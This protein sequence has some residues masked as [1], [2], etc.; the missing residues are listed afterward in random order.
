MPVPAVRGGAVEYLIDLY[1]AYNEQHQL[2]DITIYSVADKATKHHP[3]LSSAVNHYRYIN[4]FT[5]WAKIRKKLQFKHNNYYNPSIE[6]FLHQ[7]LQDIRRQHYDLIIVE[8]RPGYILKLR[9]LTDARCVLHLHN[10]F[11]NAKSKEATAIVEGFDKIICVSEFVTQQIPDGGDKSETVYNAIDVQ[12]FLDAKPLEREAIGLSKEDF[13]IVYSGRL[14]KDKGIL[15]LVEAIC[16]LTD[17]PHLK[18]LVV[19]ASAYG[20]DTVPT[21][22]IQQLQAAAAPIRDKI[23]LT[24]FID[25]Q[26]MPAYLKMANIAVVPS[27]WEEP[28][29]LTVVEAMA[30]GLPLIATRSGGIPEICEGAALLIERDNCSDQLVTAIRNLYQHPEQCQQLSDAAQQRV[31]Q[32]DKES[33]SK[34]FFKALMTILFLLLP[35]MT[36]AQNDKLSMWLRESIKTEKQITDTKRAESDMLATVF[37]RTSETLTE[38]ML[39]EY[40][41]TI[42]AQLGDISIITIPLSQ[43]GKL[44][45]NPTVLR[46]EAN[47]RADITLDTVPLVSNILPVYQATPQ[48]QAFTGS[49]VVVGLMDI[50]FDLTHPTFYNNVSLSDYRIKAFWDQLAQH[51]QASTSKLPV[52]REFLTQ[53]DILAQGCAIDG[54]M[55]GHGTHTAGIAAGSGYDSPYRGVAYESELCLVA[56]A[57]TSDTVFINPQDY[58]L[59][60]SATDALG[61]KYIFDYAEQQKKPCVVS[62]S[63]GYT[64]YMDDD[65]LLFNDFLERLIGPGRILVSSAGNES[66]ELT[67]FDKPIGK[68]QA[69]AFLKSGRNAPLYRLKSDKPVALTFYAY[70]GSNTP[71]H[72][73]QISAD[74]ERWNSVLIDTLF[75]DNDT[76]SV[77][78]NSYPSAFDQQGMISMVQ[79]YSNVTINKLPPIALVIGGKEQHATVI[80]TY[81]NALA[82]LDTDSRW[83]DASLGYNVLSPGCLK[84]PI[85]VASTSHRIVFKNMEG[86]WVQYPF[87]GEEIGLWSPYS[88]V[89][90]TLD[91]RIKPDIAAPGRCIVSAYNSYYLEEHPTATSYDV[92]H[93][94]VNGRTYP[95]HVDSGT[96]M[97][98]PVVAGII[99]LWLQA[100]PDLTRDDIMGILQRTSHHPEKDLDYPNN[101]YGYGEI[102]AYRGL[103]DILG[104]TAIKEVSQH[105]PHDAT[106]WAQDGLL[107]IAFGKIP[108]KPI[109]LTIYSTA[110]TRVFQTSVTTNQSDVTLP[111]PTFSKGIYVVQ[112]GNLG[113]TLI[114][115]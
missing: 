12:H 39:L 69:G 92:A 105:E 57:V 111:L 58:Y 100:K 74:D 54:K 41:G 19:G 18:L 84:A 114:R 53:S 93:F 104:I 106:I 109:T 101:K 78:I 7:A 9:A 48:H 5:L 44:T 10:D 107:H 71:T 45:E 97:S 103:L 4:P 66:R 72:Q 86:N 46:V 82:N 90:P 79:L 23:V 95:W 88:S 35:L 89:G 70:K 22:F 17:I 8:N 68:E 15:P 31:K 3:A 26:L 49:G 56:N 80:G 11:L 40:G 99:A 20:K 14:N 59:Y 98:T 43:I 21:P 96:S 87:N 24:G 6:Y 51:D 13:V 65:D 25:Y 47:R 75:I 94:D 55:Q 38:E 42:Y 50:G 61:F 73:L 60:T 110:G 113:S 67:Y 1:L 62:F 64:P 91:G 28:F 112:M 34:K 63:E 85:C 37:V 83:N 36:H 30:A 108:D 52:G 32:F 27:L 16:T 2:H 81:Y 29:G 115:I 33:Y 77:V 102:D 76:L